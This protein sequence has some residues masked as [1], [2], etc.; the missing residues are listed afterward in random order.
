[1][2]WL[3][4]EIG[5]LAVSAINAILSALGALINGIISTWP[6]SMPTLPDLPTGLV[7]AVGWVRWS[8]LPVDAGLAFLLFA[9]SVWVL[10][11][12]LS[13]VLRFLRV[14]E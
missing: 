10:W 3:F 14:I 8:P 6:I 1:V 5:H 7:T 12:V 4:G 11:Q 2:S 13:F 9:I